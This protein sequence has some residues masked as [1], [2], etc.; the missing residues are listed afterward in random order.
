MHQ[1]K[2]QCSHWIKASQDFNDGMKMKGKIKS[3]STVMA[4]TPNATIN[5]GLSCRI[6]EKKKMIQFHDQIRQILLFS[7]FL[8]METLSFSS[9]PLLYMKEKFWLC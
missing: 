4:F 1:I 9:F 2:Q 6:A 3:E 7:P 5:F 8:I